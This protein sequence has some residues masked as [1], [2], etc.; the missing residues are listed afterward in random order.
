MNTFKLIAD[1]NAKINFGMIKDGFLQI[2]VSNAGQITQSQISPQIIAHGKPEIFYGTLESLI[3]TNIR[4][5]AENPSL[6]QSKEA[7]GTEDVA[8]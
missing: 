4:K 7:Q 6:E 2:T 1:H 3:Q 5:A 8:G